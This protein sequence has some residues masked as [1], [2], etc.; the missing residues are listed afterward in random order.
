VMSQLI[1]PVTVARAPLSVDQ[2]SELVIVYLSRGL[3]IAR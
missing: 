1:F 2:V 3:S